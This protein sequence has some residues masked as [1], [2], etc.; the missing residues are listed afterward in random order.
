MLWYY[1]FPCGAGGRFPQ[2]PLVQAADGNFYGTT[3]QGGN[4]NN[5]GTIFKLDQRGGVSILYRF[6][7]G[8]SGALPLGLMQ[9]T[10]GELYGVAGGG[11]L[12]EGVLFQ[13]TPE[14][15]YTVLDSFARGTTGG[16]PRAAPVQDTDGH[17]YGTTSIGGTHFCG[18]VYSLD[19]GLG[20]FIALVQYTSSTSR[21]VQILGQGLTGSTGVTFNGTPASSLDVVSDTFM[22]A[23]VPAGAT[24]GPVV[25]TTPTGTLTTNKNLVV[26]GSAGVDR[27]APSIRSAVKH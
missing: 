27:R 6:S 11:S 16:N 20:P 9:A 26:T 21:T 12:N 4:Q 3:S 10:D 25:V 14:G 23:V 8:A 15:T 18:T 2:T 19:L 13:I 1:S 5:G 24:T 22:T 17:L 7:G